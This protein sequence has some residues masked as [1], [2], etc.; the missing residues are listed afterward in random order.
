MI[1]HIHTLLRRSGADFAEV[2]L[3]DVRATGVLFRGK[4]LQRASMSQDYGGNVRVL[5]GN[6]WAFY[7]FNRLEDLEHIIPRPCAPPG[8]CTT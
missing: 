7:T 3:E 2:H 4:A 5:A 1:D 8:R 6:G